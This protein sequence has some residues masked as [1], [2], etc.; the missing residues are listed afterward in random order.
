MIN[1][2]A[3]KVPVNHRDSSVI[4]KNSGMKSRVGTYHHRR[5]T[6]WRKPWLTPEVQVNYRTCLVGQCF[7]WHERV[8]ILMSKELGIFIDYYLQ[9]NNQILL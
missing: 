5:V 6:V 1:G 4:V 8:L 3:S 2:V 7:A 9:I